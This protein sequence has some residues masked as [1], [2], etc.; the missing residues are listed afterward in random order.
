MS[1]VLSSRKLRQPIRWLCHVI[2]F[3]S[4]V[5]SC[6]YFVSLRFSSDRYL[7]SS[8][9]SSR[10]WSFCMVWL[11][12]CNRSMVSSCVEISQRKSSISLFRAFDLPV[13]QQTATFR[14]SLPFSLFSLERF[15][16]IALSRSSLYCCF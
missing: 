14:S 2:W 6:T 16:L 9:I 8:C 15:S 10:L 12:S 7:V 11:L 4:L 1:L 5:V 13:A 3:L